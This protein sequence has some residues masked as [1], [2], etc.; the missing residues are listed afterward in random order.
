MAKMNDYD[1]D[2]HRHTLWMTSSNEMDM[3][4]HRHDFIGYGM[5]KDMEMV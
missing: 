3:K 1:Y 4:L 2:S 5:E